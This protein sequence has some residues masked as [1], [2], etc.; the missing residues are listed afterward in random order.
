MMIYYYIVYEYIII[1]VSTY[2]YEVFIA[3]TSSCW[4]INVRGFLCDGFD[5][6]RASRRSRNRRRHRVL[7]VRVKYNI[8]YNALHNINAPSSYSF[9]P[10]PH[11]HC[12]TPRPTKILHRGVKFRCVISRV[13]LLLIATSTQIYC[14]YMYAILYALHQHT[15]TLYTFSGSVE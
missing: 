4:F 6:L 15:H 5:K 3:A 9:H 11:H 7:F 2:Y 14:A 12:Y 10:P 13:N 1:I 8:I